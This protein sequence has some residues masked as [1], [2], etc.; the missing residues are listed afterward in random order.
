MTSATKPSLASFAKNTHSQFGE[1]GILAKIYEWIGEDTKLAV[2][3]G[4]WDGFHLSNTARLWASTSPDS[5]QA[6]L[7]EREKD[8][9]D[10]M[11]KKTSQYRVIP[12]HRSVST[13]PKSPDSLGGIMNTCGCVVRRIDLLS[14]DID[15]DDADCFETLGAPNMQAW[16]PRVVVVE[17]NPTIPNDLDVRGAPNSFCGCSAGALRKIGMDLGYVLVAVTEV[18][19]IFVDKQVFETHA[20]KFEPY[21]V[22]FAHIQNRAWLKYAATS[23]AGRTFIVG[24]RDDW[25]Y[26]RKCDAERGMRARGCVATPM[27]VMPVPSQQDVSNVSLTDNAFVLRAETWTPSIA[28]AWRHLVDSFGSD[29][30]WLCTPSTAKS[31]PPTNE[32]K[33]DRILP[34]WI[35]ASG[36]QFHKYEYVWLITDAVRCAGDWS[37]TLQ[38]AVAGSLGVGRFTGKCSMGADFLA[39]HVESY[40]TQTSSWYHWTAPVHG[41]GYP[42]LESRWKCF[43]PVVRLSNRLL[44]R[45]STSSWTAFEEVYLPTF[46]MQQ[47][48]FT[49]GNLSESSLGEMYRHNDAETPDAWRCRARTN[50]LFHPVIQ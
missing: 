39:T 41:T 14:I 27:L 28:A 11:C 23:Y 9:Y 25:P 33:A 21:D 7:I 36:E 13:D 26:L 1:D 30:V 44:Q 24:A 34:L 3:F 37:A 22:D 46:C 31:Q 50:H 47:P 10:N 4:A 5:W 35:N 12:V 48:G 32:V 38:D 43:S 16:K 49:C 19:C 29:R 15:S 8:R 2:E 40:S 17:Y 45:L 20:S 18:N 6:V 42:P